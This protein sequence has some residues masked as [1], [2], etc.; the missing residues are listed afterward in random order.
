MIPSQS[1]VSG[2]R[3]IARKRSASLVS[4]RT[5]SA[6]NNS[7]R[8]RSLL[9][10]RLGC[11]VLVHN[12]LLLNTKTVFLQTDVPPESRVHAEV[13]RGALA[14]VESRQSRRAIHNGITLP[15]NALPALKRLETLPRKRG[16]LAAIA[17]NSH[18]LANKNETALAR[19]QGCFFPNRH[20]SGKRLKASL[21]AGFRACPAAS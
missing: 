1:I 21:Q 8:I 5:S 19:T 7:A 15:I 9:T 6:G 3:S 20:A 4:P 13:T 16:T 14:P 2:S 18:L 10:T 11:F 12:V 17:R